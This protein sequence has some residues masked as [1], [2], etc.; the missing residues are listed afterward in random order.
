MCAL[1]LFAAD[2]DVIADFDSFARVQG[3]IFFYSAASTARR[4]EE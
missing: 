2:F 4:F 1:R 3:L